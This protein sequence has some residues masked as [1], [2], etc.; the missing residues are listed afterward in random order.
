LEGSFLKRRKF[1]FNALKYTQELEKVGFTSDQAQT[2]M[3]VLMEVMNENF[4]TDSK[5]RETE[6]A[7]RSDLKNVESVIK[8]TETRLRSEIKE[9]GNELRSE[10]KDLRSEMKELE[11]KLT[12]KLA[13]IMGAMMTLAIGATAT[14]LKLLHSV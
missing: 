13:T 9:L 1:V 7:L 2:S 12:I 8:D 6:F 3:K 5:L 4:A 14:V 10:M 11:Y